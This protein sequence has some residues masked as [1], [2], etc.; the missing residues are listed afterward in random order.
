MKPCIEAVVVARTLLS[1]T[2]LLC[3]LLAP[4]A[5]GQRFHMPSNTPTTGSCNLIP[6]G[7]VSTRTWGNQKYQQLHTWSYLGGSSMSGRICGIAFAACYTGIRHFD[8]IEIVLAQTKATTLSRTFAT[9]LATNV[10]TVL[11]ASNYDWHLTAGQW[12]RIGLDQNYDYLALNGNLVIQITVT[13][14]RAGGTTK[15]NGSMRRG[16]HQRLQSHDWSSTSPAS[17]SLDSKALKVEVQFRMND[18]HEFGVSCKGS[19]GYPALKLYGSGKLGSSITLGVTN[20]PNNASLLHV[21]AFSRHNPPTDLGFAGAPG[22]KLYIPVTFIA[23]AKADPWG[24]YVVKFSVPRDGKLLCSRVYTQFFVADSV[25]TLGLT[26]SNYGR[27]L[28]GN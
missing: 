16:S 27:I 19:N 9:N 22:C 14:A 17:G 6:F 8:T 10:K 25:N 7:D 20:I 1:R 4:A 11:R 3:A 18:L 21:V 23:G 15:T 24:S 2:L 13:G 28:L 5:A 12:N 26:A